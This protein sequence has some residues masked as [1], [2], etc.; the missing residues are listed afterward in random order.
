MDT[1]KDSASDRA[2]RLAQ[3]T[4]SRD[5]RSASLSDGMDDKKEG[6]S[7]DCP[8]SWRPPSTQAPQL[9]IRTVP[10]SFA[11]PAFSG[12]NVDADTWLAHFRRYAEYRQLSEEDIVAIFSLFLKD[13][14]INWFD[15][16]PR[17][18]KASSET[19]LNNFNGKT[20][21][22]CVFTKESVLLE[23]NVREKK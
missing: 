21:I 8:P 5:Q 23:Y 17:D 6:T 12:T 10:D 18:V 16:L 20:E 14:A 9:A 2:L 15:T 1:T 4:A 22:D 13:S 7:S 3:R 11:P 19:L